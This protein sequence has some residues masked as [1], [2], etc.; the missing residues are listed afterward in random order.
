MLLWRCFQNHVFGNVPSD[1]KEKPQ[2]RVRQERFFP[3]VSP[4]VPRVTY[5][6]DAVLSDEMRKALDDLLA[7]VTRLGHSSSLVSCRLVDSLPEA[8]WFPGS[9]NGTNL[10]TVQSGQFKELERLF[11]RH[12]GNGPRSLPFTVTS[13]SVDDDSPK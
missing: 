7:R 2:Q 5:L 10:R 6:W 4:A 1:D 13:Y 12:G 11:E 9:V 3:S 8:T